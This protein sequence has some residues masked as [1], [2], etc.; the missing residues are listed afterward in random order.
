MCVCVCV[1]VRVC[2]CVCAHAR[3]RV[4][5]VLQLYMAARVGINIVGM[6]LELKHVIET[7]LIR[8]S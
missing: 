8:V 5:Q 3:A 4:K 2:V 6:A 1:C 7:N